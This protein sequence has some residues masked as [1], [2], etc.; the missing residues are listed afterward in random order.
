MVDP[1]AADGGLART[2]FERFTALTSG[3]FLRLL[4]VQYRMH[5]ALM[6]F[7]SESMYESRLK[8]APEVATRTL[9]ELGVREDALR[10]GPLVF[11]DTAGKG[12]GEERSEA[13]PRPRILGRR[14]ASRSK[15][16]GC[17]RVGSRR[18]R[19]V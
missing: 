7:P 8:A 4:D 6:R 12:F 5:E 17:S 3:R 9:A 2:L 18:A 16:G 14:S 1:V 11:L 13:D 15:S 10:P 19:W